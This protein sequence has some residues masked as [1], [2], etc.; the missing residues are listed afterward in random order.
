[1][2]YVSELSLFTYI[3]KLYS[4]KVMILYMRLYVCYFDNLSIV[5]FI[6]GSIIE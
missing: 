4:M 6:R 3:N 1:M 5:F 2:K